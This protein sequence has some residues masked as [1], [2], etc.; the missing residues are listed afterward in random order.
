MALIVYTVFSILQWAQIR[1]TNRL[2][3]EALNGNGY[4][5]QETLKKL[6]G[7]IEATNVLAGHAKD[8]ADHA[9]V[10]A[11]NSGIQAAATKNA[12]AAAKTAAD[13]AK[14][15][16]HVSERAY[17]ATGSPV[18]NLD[19]N[20]VA[21]PVINTGHIPSGKL[22]I[23]IHEATVDTEPSNAPKIIPTTEQ[24]WQHYD[25]ASIPT[26]GLTFTINTPVPKVLAEKINSGHQQ[27]FLAGSISYNDGFNDTPEQVWLFCDAAS[28]FQATRKVEWVPCDAVAYIKQLTTGDHYPESE[29]H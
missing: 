2:T 5:L 3:R 6:Q 27:I 23:V 10:M 16:L 14:D 13:I 11:T 19:T 22:R 28:F 8:Q 21:I 7:Q 1:W 25:E 17:I 18:L 12:A 24:H 20:V 4:T 15:T 9:A 26:T 29:Y